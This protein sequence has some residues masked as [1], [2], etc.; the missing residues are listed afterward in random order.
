MCFSEYGQNQKQQVDEVRE[1][2]PQVKEIRD[3]NRPSVNHI[4]FMDKDDETDDEVA[5]DDY[6]V[7]NIETSE[8]IKSLEVA[9][10]K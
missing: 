5:V 10:I 9:T 1:R 6:L 4:Q 7:Q 3:N 2:Q 8:E